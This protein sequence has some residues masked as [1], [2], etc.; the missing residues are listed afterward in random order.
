MERE[1]FRIASVQ[2]A[3]RPPAEPGVPPEAVAPG[4]A[5][6]TG[7]PSANVPHLGT[8][9]LAASPRVAVVGPGLCRADARGWTRRGGEE[10]LARALGRAAEEAGFEEVR[11]GVA[12]AAVAA[13]AAAA[14]AVSGPVV[15]PSGG[16]RAFL[17]PLPLAFLP[18]PA[19]LRETFRALGL[20]RIEE[21]AKLERRELEAR[22][23]PQGLRAHRLARGEDDRVFRPLRSPEL[24][25]A[26]MEL[27]GAV[28]ELEPLLFVLRHLL[29]R[30]CGELTGEGRCAARLELKL[31]LEGAGR[32]GPGAADPPP[33]EP[34]GEPPGAGTSRRDR[35]SG[36]ASLR[37]PVVPARPTAREEP[38]FDLCRAILERELDPRAGPD[39]PVAALALRVVEATPAEARQGDLFGRGWRDPLATAAALSRLRARVGEEGVV[40]P[41]PRPDHRP[42][43]RSAWVPVEAGIGVA[44]AEIRGAPPS[45]RSEPT[46]R[47]APA[48]VPTGRKALP[49]ALRLLPRP[50]PLEVRVEGGRPVSIRDGEGARRV[51]A[52]E[53]PERLSGD[54]WGAA[55]GREY[56]RLVT[57]DGE[58]LWIFRERRAGKARWWLH[59]WWD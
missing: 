37:L 42:E 23:G 20:R 32:T 36:E 2:V 39:G 14:L 11:V 45:R 50:E 31:V 34:P 58:L 56:W 53:G 29:G 13:D 51:T 17:S 16:D 40:R 18:L 47:E 49:P 6:G 21:V 25:G 15:V 22:F 59:G 4:S 8:A 30:V 55:Y 7:V 3:P 10:A 27:Q 38:L 54:W 52:A 33:G 44:D 35:A 57:A 48:P 9:L 24:P 41:A 12:D 43:I 19:E 5:G 26:E 46:F 1:G 28:G